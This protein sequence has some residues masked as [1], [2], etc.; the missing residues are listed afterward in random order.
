M[1]AFSMDID[2]APELVIQDSLNLFEKYNV[3]CTLFNTHDS[4]V[5]HKSNRALFEIGI[6][7][8]FNPSLIDGKKIK[9]EE[10]IDNILSIVP[11]AKGVRSHSMTSSSILLDIFKSKGILYESN[12]FF[13]YNW[14]IKPYNCWTGLKKIPYNWEDDTHWLYNKSYDF[15][16]LKDYQKEN[17]IILDFHPIHVFLNTDSQQ[18]Y[19]KAKPYYQNPE[20]LLDFKNNKEFGV[21][22]FL[23]KTLKEIKK[24]KLTT[25]KMIEIID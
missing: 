12:Q 1:I 16:I 21:R 11:E 20:K 15:D 22:D 24:R 2:W 4:N 23:I 14:N 8:N 5:V 13:P 19:N 9:A 3:K 25:Y 6:H 10:T 18:T 7:P 17:M